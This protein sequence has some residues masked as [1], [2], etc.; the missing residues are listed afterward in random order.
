M[1]N[2]DAVKIG[3]HLFVDIIAIISGNLSGIT[4]SI[5]LDDK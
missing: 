1:A 3:I 5:L 2:F 4:R